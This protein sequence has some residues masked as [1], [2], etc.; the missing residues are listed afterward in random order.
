MK[1]EFAGINESMNTIDELIRQRGY[2]TENSIP[3]IFD[4]TYSIGVT[5]FFRLCKEDFWFIFSLILITISMRGYKK[6]IIIL[7]TNYRYI[8][9]PCSSAPLDLMVF[10]FS[11]IRANSFRKK[12]NSSVCKSRLDLGATSNASNKKIALEFYF[13]LKPRGSRAKNLKDRKLCHSLI[14]MAIFN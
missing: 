3:P 6:I 2:L 12:N 7:S 9:I 8:K 13:D 11:N 5:C 10:R 1:S 14:R 4:T